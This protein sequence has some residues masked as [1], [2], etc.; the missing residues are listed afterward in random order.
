MINS[1][2][3]Y[4]TYYAEFIRVINKGVN[5]LRNKLHIVTQKIINSNCFDD[6]KFKFKPLNYE[7]IEEGCYW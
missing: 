1:D 6:Y 5:A 3:E 7:K 4:Y 2:T